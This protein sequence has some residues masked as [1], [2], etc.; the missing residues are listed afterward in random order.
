MYQCLETEREGERKRERKREIVTLTG[1]LNI[2]TTPPQG[3][4]AGDPWHVRY[5]RFWLRGNDPYTDVHIERERYIRPLICYGAWPYLHV[6]A[7]CNAH[8]FV[9][10]FLES[11][12]NKFQAMTSFVSLLVA[13]GGVS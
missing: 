13:G 7:P 5:L 8:T 12:R 3:L 11:E 1:A 4:R 2:P 6:Q 10:G 9:Y